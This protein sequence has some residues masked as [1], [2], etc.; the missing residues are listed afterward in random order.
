M[1]PAAGDPDVLLLGDFNSYSKEDPVTTLEAGGYTDLAASLLGP[2]SYSYLFDGQLGHL[3][4]GFASA[5]LAPQVTGIGNW[6]INADE[7]DLFDYNDE[8]FDSPGEATFEE[9]PD[10]SALVPPRV[11]FQPGTPYRASDHD[12]VLVGLDLTS[13]NAAPTVSATVPTASPRAAPSSVSATGND[14]DSG[15][16]LTYDWDLDNNGSFETPGQTVTFSAAA[17]DGPTSRTI[18]VQVSDGTDTGVDS[19]TVN[20]NNAP[21]DGDAREQWPGRRGL[22]RE[23]LVLGDSRTLRAP[24][25]RACTTRSAAPAEPRERGLRQ[26]GHFVV[27]DL[28]VPTTARPCTRHRRG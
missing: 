20:V 2:G 4:Y 16:T 26:R 23:R 18:K 3:D 11:V 24:T 22:C 28:H 17:L 15:D 5:S 8:V 9:K 21:P 13:P 1:L 12:P 27:D 6:H 19:A 7:V 25:R 10:G 14:S